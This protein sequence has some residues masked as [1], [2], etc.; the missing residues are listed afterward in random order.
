MM[1]TRQVG[2]RRPVIAVWGGVKR[3][4]RSRFVSVMMDARHELVPVCFV[5]FLAFEM[6]QVVLR[7]LRGGADPTDQFAFL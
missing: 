4:V 3:T 2:E 6:C 5:M 7:F 1:R